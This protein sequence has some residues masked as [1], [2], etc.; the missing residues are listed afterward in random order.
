MGD[1]STSHL[2][3]NFNAYNNTR[4]VSWGKLNFYMS[5]KDLLI[6]VQHD[7]LLFDLRW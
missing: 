7:C 6:F 5:Y 4:D 1:D 3:V 2:P